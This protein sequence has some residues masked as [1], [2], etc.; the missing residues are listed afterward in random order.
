L[1]LWRSGFCGRHLL[2]MIYQLLR[3]S[4]GVNWHNLGI[5]ATTWPT[6]DMV[7]L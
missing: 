7:R 2:V 5:W 3:C 4:N 6:V 1:V